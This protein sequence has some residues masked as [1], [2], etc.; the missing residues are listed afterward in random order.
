MSSCFGVSVFFR[1]FPKKCLLKSGKRHETTHR[2]GMK[3][4]NCKYERLGV[5]SSHNITVPYLWHGS[6]RYI[7][8]C[9]TP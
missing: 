4:G 3:S 9:Q 8:W 2:A 1:T 6:N 7:L 5:F